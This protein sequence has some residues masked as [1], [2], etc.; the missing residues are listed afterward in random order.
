MT[1]HRITSLYG[2]AV[3]ATVLLLL[4]FFS[5]ERENFNVLAGLY[6]VLFMTLFLVHKTAR[7]ID[8][9]EVNAF[10]SKSNKIFMFSPGLWMVLVAGFI[11]RF[12]ILFEV[13]NLSQDFFRFI[14]DGHQLLNGFNPY[15]Y[16][17]DDIIH[18]GATHIPNARI[19]YDNMG[20]LSS[21][22][23]TNYPPLNQ[24]FFT[25]S[26]YLGS[27]SII[28]TIAFMRLFIILADLGIFLIGI[29][30]LAL[31]ELPLYHIAYYFLNPFVIV[32]LTG[33]LHWEG[34]MAF[35]LITA[36]YLLFR[37][38]KVQSAIALSSSIL[39]KLMPV[40][41]LPLIFKK[42]GASKFV[43]YGII[44]TSMTVAAFAPFITPDLI[45]KYGATVGL[46]FGK[47][48]FNASIY[49]LIRWLGFEAVGY[50]VIGTV[51]RI[52]PVVSLLLIMWISIARK[53][54][55]PQAFINSLL[56]AFFIFYLL[57]TTV[58]PWYLTIPLLLSVFTRY[59]YMLLWS[60]L[61]FLSYHAYSK[62][63]FEENLILITI[64]YAAVILFAIYE[65][66]FYPKKVALR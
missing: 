1:L 65:F 5:V 9:R 27:D 28:H 12:V 6:L 22:H 39:M 19:L 46:W 53:N 48:E 23:Y 34:V 62:E 42:L 10:T 40:I 61:V 2:L 49:Y 59:R 14:W 21:G 17:P 7:L 55:N 45:E 33:N 20:A 18:N 31:L 60:L 36:I 38:R 11:C 64:E 24:V 4:W 30:L 47:F 50:N 52:L 43:L 56:A 66:F 3:L 25:A 57:S 26:S 63:M 44:V 32:E 15:L 41:A 51:G 54:S 35:F 37:E 58:H 16:L 29:R 8:K 13:P